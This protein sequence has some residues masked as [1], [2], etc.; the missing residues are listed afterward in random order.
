MSKY[1]IRVEVS[2]YREYEVEGENKEQARDNY[3]DNLDKVNMVDEDLSEQGYIS[4][5]TK[6]SEHL[7]YST[8]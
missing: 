2:G 6:K 4:Q 1:I 7:H 8:E 3:L 5:I